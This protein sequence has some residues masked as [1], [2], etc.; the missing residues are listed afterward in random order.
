LAV[1]LVSIPAIAQDDPFGAA[2]AARPAAGSTPAAD[3]QRPAVDLKSLLPSLEHDPIVRSFRALP[4]QSPEQY[5]RGLVQL[6]RIGRWDVIQQW[7]NEMQAAP[8]SPE[9]KAALYR[10]GQADVWLRM[11]GGDSPLPIDQQQWLAALSNLAADQASS[12]AAIRESIARLASDSPVQRQRAASELL[13][14]GEIGTVELVRTF[15]TGQ[16]ELSPA[17]LAELLKASPEPAYAAVRAVMQSENH[18]VRGRILPVLARLPREVGLPELVAE[19]L[20]GEHSPLS[21]AASSLL[22]RMG[23]PVSE[24]PAARLHWL[25]QQ[26]ELEVSQAERQR[27]LDPGTPPDSFV[28]E[29]PAVAAWRWNDDQQLLTQVPLPPGLAQHARALEL[30]KL[31]LRA[32]RFQGR[33]APLATALVLEEA[34]RRHDELL[35]SEPLAGLT[36]WLAGPAFDE[37]PSTLLSAAWE[38]ADRHR[39]LGAS[40]RLTQA[41]GMITATGSAAA[42]GAR[43]RLEAA[44]LASHPAVRSTAVM[45]L[46]ESHLRGDGPV[47]SR[48]TDGL[49][50]MLTWQAQPVALVVGRDPLLRQRAVDTLASAQIS[51]LTVSSAKQALGMFDATA[52]IEMV[53][54]V[55]QVSDM[56]IGTLVE[57]VRQYPRAAGLPIGIIEG[58]DVAGLTSSQGI[59]RLSWVG[60]ASGQEQ[61]WLG[62]MKSVAELWLEPADRLYLA[63]LAGRMLSQVAAS[64]EAVVRAGL[65]RC[66]EQLVALTTNPLLASEAIDAVTA[67]AT[68]RS[69]RELLNLVCETQQ[70]EMIRRRAAQRF[71]HS[72]RQYGVKLN[73]QDILAQ[74]HRYNLQGPTDPLLAELLGGALDTIEAVTLPGEE[75]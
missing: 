65:H 16:L 63:A 48:W 31:W 47:S 67:L 15:A 51:S 52:P 69:Q 29:V 62:P 66:E 32:D 21:T 36:P 26:L 19:A 12:P 33:Q 42:D 44:L 18:Q 46:A 55:D 61:R 72:V 49:I 24:L 9:Q 25:G 14:A 68:C 64:R 1:G 50:E 30:A 35:V 39:W 5:G 13:T 22:T 54:L 37:L 27:L 73:G 17:S 58:V 71:N 38:V 41:L 59:A 20:R 10:A 43:Q 7:V 60:Q 3:G 34:F 53:L 8:W 45:A 75:S 40:L 56:K 70:P 57:R 2:P 4:P 74:Y 11:S 23:Q 28:W 6:H